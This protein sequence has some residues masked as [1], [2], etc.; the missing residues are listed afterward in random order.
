MDDR[1]RTLLETRRAEALAL[2]QANQFGRARAARTLLCA[3][4]SAGVAA[5]VA[6]AADEWAV[7]IP[8]PSLMF[9]LLSAAFQ[10][11]ADVTVLGAARARLERAVNAQLGGAGL[12]YESHVARI[13]KRP[14]LVGGVRLLQ[15]LGVVLGTIVVVVG[16]AAAFDGRPAWL[17][18]LYCVVTIAAA[19]SALVS[20]R[21]MLAS[22][23]ASAA[24]LDDVDGPEA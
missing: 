19:V 4:L 16:T 8:V 2:L 15:A 11:F 13:R 10:Q 20:F 23:P 9:V 24:A 12:V 6:I 21:G 5:I 18:L 17:S 1:A 3:L 22:G 14:P 7:A